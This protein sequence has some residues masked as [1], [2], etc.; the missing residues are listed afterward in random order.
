MYLTRLEE[1]INLFFSI[2][3]MDTSLKYK[4]ILLLVHVISFF[5]KFIAA[6]SAPE[7]SKLPRSDFF[8]TEICDL[9]RLVNQINHHLLII[10]SV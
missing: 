10:A 7:S 4:G 2:L 8:L 1:K 3:N 9:Q 5:L 6:V